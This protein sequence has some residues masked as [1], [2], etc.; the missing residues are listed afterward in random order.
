MPLYY[1][2]DIAKQIVRKMKNY[3]YKVQKKLQSAEYAALKDFS[4]VKI[5]ALSTTR[6]ISSGS[7][8]PDANR[9]FKKIKTRKIRVDIDSLDEEKRTIVGI[10]HGSHSTLKKGNEIIHTIGQTI[11]LRKKRS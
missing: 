10:L 1:F 5:K 9:R 7:D 6:S 4:Y 8:P 11:D 3:C 2:P